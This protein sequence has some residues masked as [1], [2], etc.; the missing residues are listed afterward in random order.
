MSNINDT[1]LDL[2]TV[3][4]LGRVDSR[5]DKADLVK[6][7][8][9]IYELGRIKEY[10]Q[11]HE[12]FEDYNIKLKTN[13]GTF[14]VKVFSQYKSFRHVKD[15]I[16]GLLNFASDGVEVPRLK[17]NQLG[18][19]LFYYETKETSA[20]ICVMEFFMGKSFLKWGL[21]PKMEEIYRVVKNMALINRS[22][23]KPLGIYDV[24]NVVN[25]E[26]EFAKKSEFLSSEDRKLILPLVRWIKKIDFKKYKQGTIH[27]DL[28]RS[29]ILKNKN[30]ELRVIDFSVMEYNAVVIE[31]AVFL[32]LFCINPKK[33]D[34]ETELRKIYSEVL[35]EYQKYNKLPKKDL[36][37]LPKLLAATYAINNLASSYEMNGKGNNSEETKYWIELGREGMKLMEKVHFGEK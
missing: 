4:L 32:G 14:L 18:E 36:I 9:R 27:G 28:Q 24:W 35:K 26:A 19:Y 20:L 37:I 25:L 13:K 29:N 31:L 2:N 15:N 1:W 16:Q 22:K 12:G 10:R 23:F 17:K 7:T 34:T 8:A 6:Q 21:E 5:I 11:I 3:N 30:G 33:K